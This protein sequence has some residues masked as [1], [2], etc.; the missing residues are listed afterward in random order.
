MVLLDT[1]HMSLVER[2][3]TEG[4]RIWQCIRALPPDEVATTIVSFEE[5][6]RGWLA[7]IARAATLERQIEDY[8]ELKQLLQTYCNIAVLDFDVKAAAIF[9]R[10]RQ[11]KIRIGTMDL[12]ITA[13]AL[14]NDATLLTRNLSDFGKVPDLK[15]EDW[16]LEE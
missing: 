6:T 4:R 16:T 12:K 14:A 15:A 2:G 9:E 13:I 7:R 8:S 1:D 3:G 10:L 11:A 5:Q